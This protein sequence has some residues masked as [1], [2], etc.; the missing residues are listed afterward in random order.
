MRFRLT[1]AY[2]GQPFA[3]WQ[4]QP[5]APT[6]QEALETAIAAVAG[7]RVVTGG[8]GRTDAGVHARGQVVHGEL[9]RPLPVRALVHGVN[10]HLPAAVRVLA[11]AEAPAGFDARRHA[12]AKEYSYRLSRA[13]VVSPFDAPFLWQVPARLDPHA[14]RAGASLLV[15]RHDFSA[16]AL[17]GGSHRSGVRTLFRAEWEERGPELLLRLVGDGFLRGMVRGIVGTLV[18]AALARREVAGLAGLL[19][20]GRRGDAGPT[21]PAAGLC[22]ERVFYPASWGGPPWEPGPQGSAALP[23]C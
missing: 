9:A 13:A 11:A 19:D 18:D 20:G 21:A 17:A 5:N 10:A 14:L 7:S 6:V 22:L 15:G 4:R 1:V 16:F 8:A 23:V 3:G 12:Q 2:L